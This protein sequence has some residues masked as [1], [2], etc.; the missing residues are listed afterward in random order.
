MLRLFGKTYPIRKFIL[1]TWEG[2]FLYVTLFGLTSLI[3][4]QIPS[5]HNPLPFL[6]V[7]IVVVTC[8]LS[9]YYFDLYTFRPGM[10]FLEMTVRLLQA[11]GSASI[12][13]GMLYWLFPVLL[14]GKW[15]YFVEILLFIALSSVWR[16]SYL[17]IIKRQ[18]GARPT[19]IVAQGQFPREILEETRNFPDC[20]YKIQGIIVHPKEEQA[21][22][23]IK[24]PQVLTGFEDLLG[25][26]RRLQVDE[27]IVA[28]DE[29]RGNMPIDELIACKM[30]GIE[31]T[32][33]ESFIE[34]TQGKILVDKINPS[35]LIFKEGFQKS[36]AT[37]FGKR[38]VGA[39]LSAIG[40]IAS[41]PI[42]LV[43]AVLIKLE[44][45][46]SIFY[47]Q[48]RVGKGGVP[49]EVIKFRSMTQDAEK[50]GV[51]W[52]TQNDARV[53]RV[54]RIIRKT[55]IDE[56]PQMWNVLKGEMSFV[57]PRPE[58]PE[59]VEELKRQIRFYDQRHTVQ[60][61][62]TGW[63][64]IN[65]PYGASVED[66]KKKLE[67]DL[68]YIKHMSIWLDLYIILKTVKTILFREGSR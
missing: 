56:I 31:I 45:E 38:V 66:A 54:G 1:F 2:I 47:K 53:T 8:L 24:S 34:A 15:V 23:D 14:P 30:E 43:T 19:A 55:R 9:L 68:Y 36:K 18:I 33:G 6:R 20:G 51:K 17:L 22:S 62:I 27:I 21:F 41:L 7:I 46:G 59:F 4:G 32:E 64:Q 13:L 49:F 35:W 63:A 42:T 57:G 12:F 11:L 60:P 61:G 29:R 50:N 16:Y 37:M 28:M 58:R 48:I 5:L 67:Y 3:T 52:A 44:S 65:Y 39:V 10:N 26:A 25:K 40:L